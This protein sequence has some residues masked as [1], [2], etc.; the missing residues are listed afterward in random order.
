MT[1]KF[2]VVDKSDSHLGPSV[3]TRS[4]QIG[5]TIELNGVSK[6][7]GTTCI[8][9]IDLRVAAESRVALV[10][11]SG[12]GKSTLLRMMIG[13]TAPQHGTINVF[14]A[15]LTPITA[16]NLR[17][18]MG[19]VIQEGGL[20]PH[21]DARANITLVA[22]HLGWTPQRIAERLQFLRDLMQLDAA[23][24]DR[25]P[26]QLSGGERQRIAMMRA[27]FLDPPLLL[28]D[29]PMGALDPL[30]RYALELDLRR[31]FDE[32]NKTVVL[33]TH[34]LEQAALLAHE[35]VVLRAGH[36]EQRGSWHD[37]QSTPWNEFVR[38]FVAAQTRT[39]ESRE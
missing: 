17:L 28:M 35:I 15:M 33:V 23:V 36:I 8:G 37:L 10:G 38:D 19:Y 31:I 4:D 21:L 29:E 9:P 1:R 26:L 20:F 39:I 7:F 18:Q 11:P 27:L 6:D 16:R 13:L 2:S 14:G 22:R 34:D 12:S 32:L 24:L 3:S 5:S 25:F 30:I